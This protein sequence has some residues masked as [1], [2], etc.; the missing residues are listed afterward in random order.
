M[1][2][3]DHA[4]TTAAAPQVLEA[5]LPWFSEYYGNPSSVYAAANRSRQAIA[6]AR[7][8][9]AALIG[10]RPNEIC[11][12][13]GGTEADNQ[14]LTGAVLLYREQKGSQ[15]IPHIITTK[16]EHPAVLKTCAFLEERGCA[17]TYL[18]VDSCGRVDPSAVENAIR[19]ETCIISVMT[20]NN[21]LGTI[22]PVREIGRIAHEHGVLFHTDAVQAYGHI[23]IDVNDLQADLLSASAH[24]LNGPK[25][26]GLLYIRAGLQLPQLLHG[27]GQERGRRAGTENVPGIVGF[28]KAAELAAE[29][30]HEQLER[31]TELRMLMEEE[32]KR[33]IPDILINGRNAGKEDREERLP[34]TVHVSIPGVSAEMLLIMLDRAGICASA[35]SAC[36]SGALEPSHVLRAIGLPDEL[37]RSSLRFSIGAENTREEI[38][39]VVSKLAELTGG[40]RGKQ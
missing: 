16:I 14:A 37:L 10:A 36:S 19:P 27:G 22:E 39:T 3:L 38:H 34:G 11:F 7:R 2:Y 26:T 33:Q 4:A 29:Q 28:G 15:T 17:V 12:T 25:G 1:I 24:K 20:A 32:L 21:E 6:A 8:S 13:S 18:D 23:P 30:I 5:M 31:V 35:G 9:C 40:L